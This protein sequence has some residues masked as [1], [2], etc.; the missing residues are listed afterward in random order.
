[1]LMT[2]EP[3]S[4]SKIARRE[5]MLDAAERTFTRYGLKAATMETIAEAAQ[6]SKATLY[7]YFSDKLTVFAAVAGRLAG[8]MEADVMAA[9]AG[10]GTLAERIAAALLAKHLRAFDVVI[11]SPNAAE[12]LQTR[13]H[14]LVGIFS[15]TDAHIERA[16]REAL[17]ADKSQA[18]EATARLIFN[19]AI[20]ISEHARSRAELEEDLPRLV[21]AILG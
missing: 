21:Y 5:R 15:Q 8:R 14:E 3:L 13:S 9:L 20:G 10:E 18:P 17:A 2:A 7:A 16:I 11:G 12:L 19:A 6:V 4:P 1:M